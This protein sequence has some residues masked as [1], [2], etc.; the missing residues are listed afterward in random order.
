MTGIDSEFL[1]KIWKDTAG[2]VRVA[3]RKDEAWEQE[4]VAWPNIDAVVRFYGRYADGWDAYYNPTIYSTPDKS[5]PLGAHY[6]WADFDGTAPDTYEEVPTHRVQTSGE[7]NQHVYWELDGFYDPH[8]VELANRLRAYKLDADKGSWDFGQMLRVP[9]TLNYKYDSP[10]QVT[11]LPALGE[12]LPIRLDKE[13]LIQSR[14]AEEVSFKLVE[15]SKLV[16]KTGRIQA[17]LKK[18]EWT[19]DR[20]A[21][22]FHISCLGYESGLDDNEV[23][24]VLWHADK[25]AIKKWSSRWNGEKLLAAD[26]SR[27]LGRTRN[28]SA[29]DNTFSG[30]TQNL[31]ISPVVQKALTDT[32]LFWQA[33]PELQHILT[34][35]RARFTPPWPVLGCVLARVV[36][37]IEPNF[38]LPAIVGKKASLNLFVGLV[39]GPGSGKSVSNGVAE[40]CIKW[41]VDIFK[42]SPGSGEG[43]T[44]AYKIVHKTKD[45]F[46]TIPLNSR[47]LFV[48]EEIDTLTALKSRQA[49]TLMP[50]LRK[51]Y[52]GETL[53]FAYADATKRVLLKDHEY[54]LC[55]TVGI[56]PDR[57]E[58]LISESDGG[59]PQRFL[60]MPAVDPNAPEIDPD[61]PEPLVW[62]NPF[63]VTEKVVVPAEPSKAFL[64][65][66]T[67]TE[68]VPEIHTP[69]K[70]LV[71]INVS[72]KPRDTIIQNRKNTR[73][74]GVDLL[75]GHKLLTQLKVAA[76]L[77][78][79]SGRTDVNDE[80]W[81]LAKIVMHVSDETRSEVIGS[82]QQVTARKNQ[83]R[84]HNEAVRAVVI[85]EVKEDAAKKRVSKN[86]LS[87]LTSEWVVHS[88]IRRKLKADI[89]P[90]FEDVIA[91]LIELGQVEMKEETYNSK[92]VIKY[93]LP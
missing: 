27:L 32:E 52:M 35:S 83:A 10:M 12:A 76:A 60:W 4:Y 23:A 66:G 62:K 15:P 56:Q 73:R 49:S 85:D 6:V 84:A 33:R 77:A 46:E 54:R 2:Y 45:G 7:F 36:A 8:T 43:L 61:E 26:I 58:Q 68:L 79:L 39:G 19:K 37:S 31:A 88:D 48:A 64:S 63:E 71:L 72:G 20:S 74:T 53:G 69:A 34:F 86:I 50:E 87:K 25:N 14:D 75:D 38:V 57:A 41:P 13:L 24:T 65:M 16:D 47:A 17:Y 22:L 18:G 78:F 11:L 91:E 44:R 1:S 82:I 3:V 92:P 40:D 55:L 93:K 5:N 70:E 89:R 81:D 42:T 29:K 28:R 21:A 30:L 51:A 59:T 90:M 9:G 80:D 67:D